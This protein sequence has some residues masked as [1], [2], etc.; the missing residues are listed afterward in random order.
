MQALQNHDP[1]ITVT[2]PLQQVL[3]LTKPCRCYACN[4][5]CKYGSGAFGDDEEVKKFA[6][7]LNLSVEKAKEQYLEVVEKFETKKLRPKIIRKKNLPYGQCIF[8]DE[9]QGCTIHPVKPL[10]CKLAMPCKPYGEA[11]IHWFTINYFVD[12]KKK[13]SLLAWH[14]ALQTHPSIP[15]SSLPELLGEENLAKQL[16]QEYEQENEKQHQA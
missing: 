11:L 1:K 9:K 2:T 7:Y 15:G 4:T 3:A 6:A 13:S 5:G 12:K 14:R 16:L 10:E 8:Y